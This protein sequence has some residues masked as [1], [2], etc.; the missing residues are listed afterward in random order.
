VLRACRRLLKPTGHIAYTTI[1]VADGLSK[2]DHRRAAEMGP[3]AVTST[4]PMSELMDAAGFEETEITDVTEDFIDTAGAWLHAFAE[5]ER[6]LRPLLRNQFD[7][8][9]KGRR[10]M[11]AG[12][13]EG[14]LKRLIVS[15]KASSG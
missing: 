15:A 13:R 9:Q 14:L 11:I 2:S 6:E 12:A 5:R 7:D 8:R 10:E 1:V 4:R 3:R